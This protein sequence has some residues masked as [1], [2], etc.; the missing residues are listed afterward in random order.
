MIDL[1]DDA[2]KGS[3]LIYNPKENYMEF[4]ACIGFDFEKLKNVKLKVEELFLYKEN[5]L[6]EASIIRNPEKYD[7][8]NI[9]SEKYTSLKKIRALDIKSTISVPLYIDSTFFGIVNIDSCVSY[10][11]FS[12]EDL[13]LTVYIKNELEMAMKNIIYLNKLKEYANF[14]SLT[15]VMNKRFFCENFKCIDK[16]IVYT[17]VYIDL[18][19]FKYINDTYGHFKGDEVL[20]KFCYVVNKNIRNS[21]LFARVGGDEFV[22]LFKNMNKENAKAKINS[23]KLQLENIVDFSFGLKE[24]KYDNEISLDELLKEVD[25]KMYTQKKK[26]SIGG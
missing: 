8:L 5:K 25:I 14:D 1:I 11:S 6:K 10:S 21:D 23:I 22:L 12:D 19:N 20:K 17:L 7:R 26:T 3:I 13:K 4:K 16:K 9:S 15:G 18:N 24:F 2:S